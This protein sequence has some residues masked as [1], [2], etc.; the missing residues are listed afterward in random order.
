MN[1]VIIKE[2]VN[3]E[4]LTKFPFHSCLWEITH[5]ELFDPDQKN[6]PVKRYYK[7]ITR[8]YDNKEG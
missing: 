4:Q 5:F 2:L 3:K 1:K 7:Q 6:K 8:I